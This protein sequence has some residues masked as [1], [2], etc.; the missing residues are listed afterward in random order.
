MFENGFKRFYDSLEGIPDRVP[1]IAQMHEF[2]MKLSEGS[3]K[4]FY[5]DPD[6]IVRSTIDA[7]IDFGFDIP[8]LGYDVYNIEAEALGIPL[9]YSDNL[10][11]EVASNKPLIHSRNDLVKLKIPDPY[12]SGRMPFVLEANKLYEKST[13]Y[14]PPIQFTAPFSVAITLRG[15]EN[16]ILDIYQQPDFAHDVLKFITEKILAPW[17]QAMQKESPKA[18]LYRGADAM[19]SMPLVNIHILREFVVPYIIKLKQLCGQE[20]TVLNWWGES[21]LENPEKMLALKLKIS[22]TIVQGQDPDVEKIGPELYK[23]FAVKH[24]SALILGIGNLFLQKAAKAE[25][26]KRIRHYIKAGASGGRFMIYFCY[27][28]SE[29]PGENVKAAIKAVKDSGVY[30][31]QTTN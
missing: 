11:P 18:T 24:D 12:S 20:I 1:F 2:A 4:I 21:H 10:P 9:N 23:K 19:A 17:I 31:N 15:F 26:G 16:F 7:A 5:S 28:S 13:G 8:W 29:T 3:A 30:E 14:P 22:P 27:L 6:F 25:I